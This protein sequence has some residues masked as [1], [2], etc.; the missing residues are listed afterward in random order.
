MATPINGLPELSASQNQ[1]YLTVNQTFRRLDVLVNLTVFN[2][3]VTA[4]PGG[5]SD[6]DRY[7]V[8]GTA[9]GDFTGQENN[10]A[11]FL[12]SD[13]IFFTPSEGWRAYDQ[14]ADEFILFDG[15]N[16]V[17]NGVSTGSLSDG[18]INLLGIAATPD[19]TNRFSVT[20]PGVLFNAETDD[21]RLTFNKATAG[22]DVGFLLQTGFSTRA[23]IGL[24]SND[25]F[26]IKVTP[27][28][29]SF[30]DAL[31]IDKDDG[32]TK[33][34]SGV[35]DFNSGL[36]T[37]SLIPAVV[38]DI[39]RINESSPATP[40]TYT[41]SS[42]SGAAITLT[43]SLAGQIFGT[44]MRNCTMVRIWNTSKSPNQS[45]WVNW[46]NSS[47]QINVSNS[48]DISS[49]TPGETIQLG[50]PNPT[51]SNTLRMIALDIS[52][53][54]FNN[55]GV[56]WRQ[57][58]VLLSNQPLGVGG[59]AA[60]DYSGTGAF[61]SALGSSSNSDGSRQSTVQTIFT[62][63]LSPISNSN[64]IFVRENLTSPAT[65]LGSARLGRIIG[66]YV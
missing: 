20:S 54:M 11:M 36:F 30:F 6:G 62:S 59:V 14:G 49:W 48:S 1:K 19:S 33:F 45:A 15:S 21:F 50:D 31:V 43:A 42:I 28:G 25:D 12:G 34:P 58:G 3:T 64:L 60:M 65:A 52:N 63:E 7:I 22:D 32:S 53:Y 13:W 66:L 38:Q 8:A 2:R 10:V 9:T 29:S 44:E 4:P 61:G 16:W 17:V 26:T 46:N 35:R 41:I 24:L 47:D 27:D 57:K 56:I 51:G 23:L 18:S 37:A 55:Y 40:R 5:P 39:W